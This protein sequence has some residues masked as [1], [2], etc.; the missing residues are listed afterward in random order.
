MND[1]Y[2][3]LI[4]EIDQAIEIA[5]P[6]E[7]VFRGLVDRL[8]SLSTGAE[9]APMPMKLEEWP[10]GRWFR[11]LGNNTGHLWAHVQSIK[12]PLLLELCGPMCF[13]FATATNLIFRLAPTATGTQITL[14]HQIMGPVP[15][16][17]RMGM[18]E[19]WGE[20]LSDIKSD[21]EAA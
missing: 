13:S 14:R 12:P 5:A 20:M 8:S 11:D 9:N 17:Y 4:F 19:G 16:D 10:G 3:Q 15:D 2:K 1:V 18:N 21:V 7:R 6:P